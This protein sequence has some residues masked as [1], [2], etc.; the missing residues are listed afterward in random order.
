MQPYE[1]LPSLVRRRL[2]Y[3]FTELCSVDS[4]YDQAMSLLLRV[5]S[6][7]SSVGVDGGSYTIKCIN[8]RISTEALILR[9]QLQDDKTWAAETINEHPMP[10]KELW[11]SWR[12]FGDQLT[13]KK[14]WDDL[15]LHPMV[16]ITKAED[17]RLR[18]VERNVETYHPSKRYEQAGIVISEIR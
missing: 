14:I 1:S 3:V 15:V 4:K 9:N 11:K 12:A 18:K 7:F 8:H 6:N 13:E 5:L 16:T 10:L 2:S 17:A